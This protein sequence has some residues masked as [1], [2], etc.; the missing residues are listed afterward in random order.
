MPTR[1]APPGSPAI[2]PATTETAGAPPTGPNSD[3]EEVVRT[4]VESWNTRDFA[5]EYDALGDEMTGGLSRPDYIQRRAQ[6]YAD[7]N[8]S[9]MTCTVLDTSAEVSSQAATVACLREDTVKGTPWRKDERYTLRL[10]PNG[11]KLSPSAP[12]P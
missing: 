9:E 4:F 11:W 7:E 1:H 10:S 8:G 2:L 6:L 5:R 3:P 12:A